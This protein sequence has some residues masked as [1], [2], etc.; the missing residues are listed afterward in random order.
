MQDQQLIPEHNIE[1]PEKPLEEMFK[2]QK[3]F[4]ARF[5]DFS[6]MTKEEW[7]E[8]VMLMLTCIN[9]EQVEAL[10]WL[11]NPS[12]KQWKSQIEPFNRKE[13]INELVDIQHFLINVLLAVDCNHE[14]FTNAFFNKNYENIKRQEKGY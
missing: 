8:Y 7:T 11:T 13:F 9:V 10:N 12:W 14:E 5:Y 1:I 4:Q 2:R 3:E 6:D